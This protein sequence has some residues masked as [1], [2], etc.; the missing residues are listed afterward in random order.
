VRAGDGSEEHERA[1]LHSG[2]FF[3]EMSLLTGAPRSA[4]VVALTDVE[5]YRLDADVFQRML[6]RRTDLAEKVA[7][8][9]SERRA[10]LESRRPAGMPRTLPPESSQV[11]WSTCSIAFAHFSG[12]ECAAQVRSAGK[13]AVAVARG[14][15]VR[16][17]VVRIS[18]PPPGYL[19][20]FRDP[21]WDAP[22]DAEREIEAIPADAQIRGMFILPMITELRRLPLGSVKMRDRYLPFEFYPLREHARLLIDASKQLFPKQP[23]RLGLRK[24]GRGAPNAF[25]TSTL[26]RVVLQSV[27][28]VVAI[29]SALA[30][31]Y[32]L[33]LK[34]GR[35]QVE[36]IGPR[37]L[38]VRFD[39][40]YYFLD[41]HHVGAFEGAAKHAGERGR[42]RVLRHGPG[43]AS[44]LLEW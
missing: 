23:L 34:P 6:S 31:G 35:A 16:W 30:K 2:A 44:L 22:L 29:A 21:P 17:R 19:D 1:Q 38:I 43:S 25:T 20:T 37:G 41:S 18:R 10:G 4:T 12:C 11:D 8:A 42:V 5:C 27:E 13:H 7:K 28:G 9:L 39:D 14:A 36:V 40:V 33:S 3:G 24:L 15:L 26:G 32:E